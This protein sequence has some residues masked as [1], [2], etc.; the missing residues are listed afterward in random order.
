MVKMESNNK[1]PAL[2]KAGFCYIKKE[3]NFY[4]Y[5]TYYTLIWD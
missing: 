3:E 1:K 2:D 5:D 4:Y